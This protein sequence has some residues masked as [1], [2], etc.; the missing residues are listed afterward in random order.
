MITGKST[1]A[2]KCL[3]N[4]PGKHHLQNLKSAAREARRAAR[5]VGP[6][7]ALDVFSAGPTLTPISSVTSSPGSAQQSATSGLLSFFMT[8]T[9]ADWLFSPE[10]TLSKSEHE[11]PLLTPLLLLTIAPCMDLLLCAK[12]SFEDLF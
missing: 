8:W 3:G 12:K 1:S 11:I 2:N 5:T 10:H 6:A 9:M 4:L 7:L